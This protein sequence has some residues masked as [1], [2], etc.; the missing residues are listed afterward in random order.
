MNQKLYWADYC[1]QNIG[2]Y[3]P[4]TKER[5][6]LFDRLAEPRGIVVDPTTGYATLALCYLVVVTEVLIVV[7][8]IG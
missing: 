6:V 7:G 3:D 8:Y 1:A 2:V 5:T 4:S